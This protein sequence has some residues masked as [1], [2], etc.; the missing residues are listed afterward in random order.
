MFRF[1]RSYTVLTKTVLVYSRE[2]I[3]RQNWARAK[4]PRVCVPW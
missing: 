3:L 2:L 1:K 4:F